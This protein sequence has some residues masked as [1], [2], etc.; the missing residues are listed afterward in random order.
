MMFRCLKKRESAKKADQSKV[1]DWN[2]NILTDNQT[3]DPLMTYLEKEP[4]RRREADVS[5]V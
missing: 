4:K 1:I 2:R 5:C 3:Y